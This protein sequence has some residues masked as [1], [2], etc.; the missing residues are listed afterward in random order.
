M[1]VA[2]S[3]V[4]SAGTELKAVDAALSGVADTVGA[5]TR[6]AAAAAAS[7]AEAAAAAKAATKA[8]SGVASVLSSD[9]KVLDDIADTKAASTTG[10]VAQLSKGA[11]DIPDK[12]LLKQATSAMTSKLG[13]LGIT[14]AGIASYAAITGKSVNDVVREITQEAAGVATSAVSGT[15]CGAIG[16]CAEDMSTVLVVVAAVFV[17]WTVM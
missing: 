15:A 16:I 10:A 17:V 5:A 2:G 11:G 4:G 13:L 3:I 7:A 6:K 9:V 12:S 1:P 14:A 8:S